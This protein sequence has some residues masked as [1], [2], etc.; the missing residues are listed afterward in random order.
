MSTR[1][2]A[3]DQNRLQDTIGNILALEIN[4]GSLLATEETVEDD[5]LNIMTLQVIFNEIRSTLYYFFYK[6]KLLRL[7][8]ITQVHTQV[9]TETTKCVYP[10]TIST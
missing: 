10:I 1:F 6:I 2:Y 7:I 5:D 8:V 3:I 4:I 9:F